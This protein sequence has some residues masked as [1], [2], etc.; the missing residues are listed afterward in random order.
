[1]GMNNNT[2]CTRMDFLIKVGIGVASL[3]LTSIVFKGLESLCNSR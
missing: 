2:G 3:A 1:M